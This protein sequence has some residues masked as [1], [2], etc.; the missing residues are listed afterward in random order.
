VNHLKYQVDPLG[1]ISAFGKVLGYWISQ[2][3][4]FNERVRELIEVMQG[5]NIEDAPLLLSEVD[6]RQPYIQ[7]AEKILEYLKHRARQ[8]RKNHVVLTNWLKNIVETTPDLN[9]KEKQ[10]AMFWTRQM[11]NVISPANFFWTNPSA[12]QRFMD[13]RGK[14]LDDGLKHW[15]ADVQRG[16]PLAKM[17]DEQAFRIGENIAC[18]PG[19]I[20]FRNDLMELIQ[21]ESVTTEAYRIPIV[22]IPPWINKYYIFDLGDQ[23]SFVRFLIQQGFTVFMIS[24]KNPTA[25]MRSVS[26]EDYMFQGG[27]QAIAVVRDVTKAPAVHVAA[28]CIGGTMLAALLAWMNRSPGMKRN[29]PVKDWTVLA[30]LVDFSEPGDISVFI[31]PENIEFIERRM[32]TDGYLD[33][34]YISWVFRLLRSDSLIWQTCIQSYLYGE[35]PPK[36]DVLFWNGDYTRLPEAMCSYYLRSCY[37]ENRLVQKD[38]LV[39]R[40]KPIDLGRITQPLYSVGTIQDHIS[41]WKET[42]KISCLVNGPTH[43][44]LAHEGHIAGIVNPPST[45]SRKRYWAAKIRQHESPETWLSRQREQ[46]GSWWL[47][48]VSWLIEQSAEKIKCPSLGSRKHPPLVEAPGIYV[49]EH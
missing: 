12:V 26:F 40:K 2:P 30:T 8:A 11:I 33:G 42:F 28:Y 24:W 17:A 43:F 19:K 34:K 27:L 48:W 49:L 44:V 46:R 14:S 7:D 18:T 1:I 39:L 5:M 29:F 16:D 4:T 22:F 9:D 3:N 25:D 41:P 23:N 38:S 15:L 10:C 20:I 47:D 37:L 32:K 13:S 31:K 6:D 45:I 35:T 21:Y 36:S